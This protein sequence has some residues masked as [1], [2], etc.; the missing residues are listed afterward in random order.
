MV[1]KH[2]LR[3]ND[4]LAHYVFPPYL[5]NT[6]LSTV[7][8]IYS[9]TLWCNTCDRACT[10]KIKE[11]VSKNRVFIIGNGPSLSHV[12]IKDLYEEDV[13]TMNYFNR[14]QDSNGIK[15]VCHVA[16]DSGK[17]LDKTESKY[18][19]IFDSSTKSYL[20]HSDARYIRERS[21]KMQS[22]GSI[23]YF[24]PA[25]STLD[26]Y[27]GNKFDFFKRIPRP[28]NSVQLAIMLAMHLGYKKI[29]LLGVDED[30]LSNKSQVNKHFYL[31]SESDLNANTSQLSYLDRLI[32]KTKTFNGFSVI[33]K[34]SLGLGVEIINLNPSS[35]LDVFDFGDLRSVLSKRDDEE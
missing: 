18:F 32:G 1:K 13:V 17:D 28:R 12:N 23:C 6:I 14:H 30:Q 27:S 31:E 33:K 25:I 8:Y 15:A 4:I 9:N 5:Y 10:E 21:N 26:Q 24:L 34:V 22:I 19:E 3:I 35:R 20:L 7:D 29:Y 11:Q 2:L 16:A